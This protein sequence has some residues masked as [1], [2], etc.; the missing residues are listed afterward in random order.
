VVG[1]LPI[2]AVCV[3]VVTELRLKGSTNRGQE[4]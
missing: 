1:L 2:C 4:A 3:I